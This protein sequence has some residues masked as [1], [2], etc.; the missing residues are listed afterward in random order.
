M[1]TPELIGYIRGKIA[2]GRTREE[3]RAELVKSGGW[4]DV[5]LSD[6]FR[7]VIPMEQNPDP[8]VASSENP[9]AD[10]K[11]TSVSTPPAM[12]S[13][14][15]P[16]LS[17]KTLQGLGI[18]VVVA[19]LILA[20][21][22][23]K[24]QVMSFWS[25]MKDHLQQFS[26]P[27]FKTKEAPNAVVV[28]ENNTTV[29][30]TTTATKNC[31]TTNSPDLK[32]KTTYENNASLNCLGDS[33]LRCVNAQVVLRND[34][35]P[36]GLQIVKGEKDCSF[37]LSYLSDSTLVD[38]AGKKLAGQYISCPLNMVKAVDET[39]T[40]TAFNAPNVENLAKYASQIYFY[41]TL[42]VFMENNVD[43][44]KIK[45]LGCNGGYISGVVE[46]YKQAQN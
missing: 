41:G 26:L 1:V 24:P 33:A 6:A 14:M 7:T 27:S 28:N 4:S 46:S 43:E 25:S 23:Y 11:P 10:T 37:T 12:A 3:I 18:V 15:N 31:G 40:P 5:D 19:L 30:N 34:L 21:F 38:R 39:E 22:Y 16:E 42:G 29:K 20:G 8:T 13:K 45:A 36:T 2:Q 32:N 9:V 35:L 17:Q 44:N